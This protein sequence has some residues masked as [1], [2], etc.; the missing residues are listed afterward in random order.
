MVIIG[1]IIFIYEARKAP[2]VDDKE[3]FLWGDYDDRKKATSCSES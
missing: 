3:P 2:I 1:I